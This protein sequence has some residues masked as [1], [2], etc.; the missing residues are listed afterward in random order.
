[1]KELVDLGQ[2]RHKIS[3][4]SSLSLIL[5]LPGLHPGQEVHDGDH[6][7]LQQTGRA[8]RSL[9]ASFSA[10]APWDFWSSGTTFPPSGFLPVVLNSPIT[11]TLGSVAMLSA[12][13]EVISRLKRLLSLSLALV[14]S[15]LESH[16]FRAGPSSSSPSSPSEPDITDNSQVVLRTGRGLYLPEN[17][18]SEERSSRSSEAV[19]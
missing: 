5:L 11:S 14:R 15:V 12:G 18:D 19:L 7:G 4:V 10:A 3:S 8:T 17:E 1:M 6:A 2:R 16:T 13:V 9:A